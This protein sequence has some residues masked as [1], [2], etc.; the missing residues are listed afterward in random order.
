MGLDK[1][2]MIDIHHYGVIK[3]IFSVLKSSVTSDLFIV[4]IVLSFPECHIVG[5]TE[6]VTFTDWLLLLKNIHLSFLHV[7]SWLDDPFLFNAE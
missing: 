6:Y 7:Y 4:Y 5:I 3:T 1:C 2:I